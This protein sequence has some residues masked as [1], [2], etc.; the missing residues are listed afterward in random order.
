MLSLSG[1]LHAQLPCPTPPPTS[2]TP[3]PESGNGG[4][5]PVRLNIS[6][7]ATFH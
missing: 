4:V 2:A 3:G 1:P 6:P 5:A 7:G